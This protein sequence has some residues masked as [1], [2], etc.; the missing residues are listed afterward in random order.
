MSHLSIASLSNCKQAI[1]TSYYIVWIA[2]EIKS[3]P[4]DD[5]ENK[6]SIAIWLTYVKWCL[7]AKTCKKAQD[8]ATLYR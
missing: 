2:T 4:L 6:R 3:Q 5:K 7:E 8:E 1:C